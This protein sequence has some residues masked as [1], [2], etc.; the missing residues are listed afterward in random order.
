MLSILFIFLSHNAFTAEIQ[1][2]TFSLATEAGWAAGFELK[3]DHTVV[4][5]PAFGNE[6][7]DYDSS[8]NSLTKK[9]DVV[10]KWKKTQDGIEV[11]YGGITDRFKL[12]SRCKEYEIHPCFRFASSRSA[13]REKSLLDYRQPYVNRDWKIDPPKEL[14][15]PEFEKCK[16]ECEQMATKKELKSGVDAKA[17]IAATCK[18]VPPLG[19]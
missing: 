8:G 1:L 18:P 15:K 19:R 3:E 10:G 16:K 12:E 9:P 5:T 14:P 17:C 7:E 6:E 4:I 13:K 11:I 2:G